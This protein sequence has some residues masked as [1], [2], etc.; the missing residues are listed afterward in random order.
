VIG[1]SA[2]AQFLSGVATLML[3]PV[4]F[5]DEVQSVVI[6]QLPAALLAMAANAALI[7]VAGIF[8]A[9]LALAGGFLLLVGLQ[10]A[11]NRWRGYLAIPFER[12]RLVRAALIYGAIACAFLVPRDFPVAAEVVLSLAGVA[13]VGA[14]LLVLLTPRERAAARSVLRQ[15]T[16]H[17]PL[18]PAA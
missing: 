5:A 11:W 18:S 1:L 17:Q 2:A 14:A 15:R 13:L 6:V 10:F 8:G 7:P 16:R 3:P 4:Y 9:G 12:S